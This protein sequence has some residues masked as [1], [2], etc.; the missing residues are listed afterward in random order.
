MQAGAVGSPLSHTGLGSLCSPS[1]QLGTVWSLSRTPS[2]QEARTLPPLFGEGLSPRGIPGAEGHSLSQCQ[3]SPE[4]PPQIGVFPA[5]SFALGE[6]VVCTVNWGFGGDG[7]QARPRFKMLP[8]RLCLPPAPSLPVS[9]TLGLL[10]AVEA[11]PKLLAMPG[12]GNPPFQIL[13]V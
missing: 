12:R 3:G 6:K 9:G 8:A 7:L 11:L 10:P 2:T 4:D 1:T 13:A 5:S